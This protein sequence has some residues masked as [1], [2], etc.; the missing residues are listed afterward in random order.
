M[1]KLSTT[2]RPQSQA[3]THQSDKLYYY[4]IATNKCYI[5]NNVLANYGHL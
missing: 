5:A 3:A 4:Y 1:S 2:P